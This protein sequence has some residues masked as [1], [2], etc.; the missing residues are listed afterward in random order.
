[1]SAL[2]SDRNTQERNAEVY[3]F[4]IAPGVIIYR[5]ALVALNAAGQSLRPQ[6]AGAVQIA[7][8]AQTG[9]ADFL[10]AG[11]T[12]RGAFPTGGL[13]IDQPTPF[14]R[15]RRRKQ[16]CLANSAVGPDQIATI[17]FG[18]TAYAVDDQTVALTSNS[19]ARLAVG[20]IRS[21]DQ[22]GVWVEI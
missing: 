7:G 8:I 18:A 15:V 2:T 22:L 5:G 21:V 13:V 9:S 16:F 6:D 1:M 12:P 14:V 19:G 20:I 11:A 10:P 3:E 17:N 4:P